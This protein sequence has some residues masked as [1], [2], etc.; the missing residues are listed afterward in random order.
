MPIVFS[1][2]AGIFFFLSEIHAD[3]EIYFF[4]FPYGEMSLTDMFSVYGLLALFH[5]G[6]EHFCVPS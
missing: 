2:V 1:C 3:Q 6:G 4:K 5:G